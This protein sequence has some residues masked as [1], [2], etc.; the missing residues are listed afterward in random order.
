[1]LDIE[2]HH[3]RRFLVAEGD[4]EEILGTIVYVEKPKIAHFKVKFCRIKII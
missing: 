1:M 4:N 2:K 3:G